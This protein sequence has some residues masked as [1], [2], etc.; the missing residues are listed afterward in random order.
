MA[1]K[2]AIFA[3][4]I[5]LNRQWT[6]DDIRQLCRRRGWR[7]YQLAE[8]LGIRRATVSDW[9]RG[10]VGIPRMASVALTLLDAYWDGRLKESAPPHRAE[11]T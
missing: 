11:D 3:R 9:V 2:S 4:M 5:D 1:N 10:A 8:V 6:G 7:Q